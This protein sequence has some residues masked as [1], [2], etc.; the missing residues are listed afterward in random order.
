MSLLRRKPGGVCRAT[1][2]LASGML[3]R[4]DV[5][6]SPLASGFFIPQAVHR[7]ETIVLNSFFYT[8]AI[9]IG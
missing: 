4:A 5:H 3:Y 2:P 8:H 9:Q 6:S 1:N 7:N